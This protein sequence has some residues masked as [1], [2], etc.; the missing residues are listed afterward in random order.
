MKKLFL[1]LCVYFVFV[2]FSTS[3]AQ[4]PTRLEGYNSKDPYSVLYAW[5][6]PT[7]EW[8]A[9]FEKTNKGILATPAPKGCSATHKKYVHKIVFSSEPIIYGKEDESKFTNTFEYAQPIYAMAYFSKPIK[10]LD[11]AKWRH[12]NLV[13]RSLPDGEPT[14]NDKGW[15]D[16][17]NWDEAQTYLSFPVVKSTSDPAKYI[18]AF[19]Q[20]TKFE[21]FFSANERSQV[22]ASL[23]D[24]E[25]FGVLNV[26]SRVGGYSSTNLYSMRRAWYNPS[27][28]DRAWFF[29]FNN[30]SLAESAPEGSSAMHKK[31]LHRIVY[32][33]EPIIYGQEDES[34]FTRNFKFGDN[35]YA[36]AYLSKT[37]RELDAGNKLDFV[38][39]L[40]RVFP[41]GDEKKGYAS[42]KLTLYD[43]ATESKEK[44]YLSFYI[45]KPSSDGNNYYYSTAVCNYFAKLGTYDNLQ[46]FS[47]VYNDNATGTFNYNITGT[48]ENDFIALKKAFAKAAE[49]AE[50]LK[51][52]AALN[53]K[54]M[55]K[56]W[57]EQSAP[58]GGGITLEQI[59]SG[60]LAAHPGSTVVKIVVHPAP[61]PLWS[62][63]TNAL[64]I[65]VSQY[66][67]QEMYVFCKDAS[68][69]WM[70]SVDFYKDYL[71]GGTYGKPYLVAK[72]VYGTDYLPCSKMK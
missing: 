58:L 47:S 30:K 24:D 9:W 71:G 1:S 4:A 7:A 29:E 2:N 48:T 53:S 36:M 38:K 14:E 26:D 40:S 46:L 63:N 51:A 50:K 11:P 32:S 64:G 45:M 62:V 52:D 15:F 68:G 20:T 17:D 57:T 59:K 27:E 31:Y 21:W 39:I 13:R 60:Y 18:F 72:S 8:K 42:E 67:N 65:P 34:K 6:N 44:T 28:N 49:P 43:V 55:P 54:E 12:L 23:Y 61:Q 10:D 33:K 56:E 69:C 19:D 5:Y 25:A 37:V 3:R 16:Y 66:N 35:I 22:L 70:G 41:S